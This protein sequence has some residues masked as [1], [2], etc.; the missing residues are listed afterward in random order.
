MQEQLLK[1]LDI[2]IVLHIML[3][4]IRNITS[5]YFLYFEDTYIA[6]K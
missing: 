6:D 4:N 2:F 3:V 1:T 5:L